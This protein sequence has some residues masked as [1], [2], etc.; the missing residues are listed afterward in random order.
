MHQLWALLLIRR[1]LSQVQ[2][3]QL[4]PLMQ[5]RLLQGQLI[6]ELAVPLLL[7]AAVML[8]V[9]VGVAVAVAVISVVLV[10]PEPHAAQS[11]HADPPSQ[12]LHVLDLIV[13]QLQQVQEQ[14]W[15]C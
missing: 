10:L 11:Q 14:P 2:V 3:P 4:L 9:A 12:P 13:H 5:G 1:V 6:Q 7:A 8:A 15:N